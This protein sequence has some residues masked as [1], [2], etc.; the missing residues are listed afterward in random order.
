MREFLAEI[1]D[2][3]IAFWTEVLPF[4]VAVVLVVLTLIALLALAFIAFRYFL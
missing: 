2:H 3:Y 4:L 1:A